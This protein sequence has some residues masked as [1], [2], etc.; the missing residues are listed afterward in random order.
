MAAA[1]GSTPPPAA[2]SAARSVAA[3][4]D[5]AAGAV[6]GCLI[7]DALGVGPHW[8]CDLDVLRQEF[9]WV[10][11]YVQSKPGRY[12]EGLAPGDLSQTGQVCEL[13]LR[14]LVDAGRY[15]QPDFCS[16]LDALLGQ[17]DGTPYSPPGDYTDVAMRDV[18]RGRKKE[19]LQWG[20]GALG[21]WCDT[22]EGAIRAVMLAA[23]YAG[24]L[25]E[26]AAHALANVRV[27]HLDPVVTGQS[28]SFALLVAAMIQGEPIDAD[29][30]L[31]MRELAKKGEIPV[32]HA[33]LAEER[34]TITEQPA[35]PTPT[36]PF[37]DALL[38]VG[39]VV[40]AARDPKVSFPP[41]KV[42]KVYGMACSIHFLLPAAYY[43]AVAFEKEPTGQR[44]FEQAVLHAINS[45]GNNMARAAL[46]GAL[47]GSIVGLTGIP[48]RF[49]EGLTK[50]E[51]LRAL[52]LALAEQAFPE[53][54]GGRGAGTIE[55]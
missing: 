38:Q 53:A 2:A 14:S 48:S 3:Q 44:R 39:W 6:L 10:G 17:L 12:H 19:G 8:Y 13:L 23:R 31:K 54:A 51:E 24:S 25:G 45:G 4:R 40:E 50:G 36:M 55:A 42:G 29:L 43:L 28:M 20:D 18:W 41:Q 9:G 21:S 11:G 47:V 52:A 49:V 35:D 5:R 15:D 1:D 26:A 46:T 22:S 16:R 32:T 7:G 30:G 33:I 34:G 27:T 37:P